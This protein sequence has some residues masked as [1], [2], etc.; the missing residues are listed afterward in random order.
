MKKT[1]LFNYESL[2]HAT[3]AVA[4]STFALSTFYPLDLIKF[5]IQLQDKDL[6]DKS[7]LQ[8]ILFILKNEGITALY[9][10]LRVTVTTMGVSN[11]VYFY[12]FHGIKGLI[13]PERVSSRTDFLL[14]IAAGVAN[15]LLTN[16]LWVA[17]NRLKYKEEV[18]FTGLLD[19]MFHIGSTEGI[20]ALWKGAAPSLMLVSNPVIHF[21]VYEALKRR[22]KV[23]S[24]IGFFLLSAVSKSIA[25]L[26]TYPLQ[27]AQTRQRLMKKRLGTAALLLTILKNQGPKGLYQGMESKMLQTVLSTAL[28]FVMYEKI[29]QFVFKLLLGTAK[30]KAMK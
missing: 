6:I 25:T 3:A 29:V 13:P 2:V 8:A 28:M 24:A 15:V 19:G 11:F 7:T 10:G 17:N 27:L 1:S 18:P 26:I 22:V 12:T 5:R 4:G 16:P 20:S 14:S 30:R 21:T 9:R 23:N